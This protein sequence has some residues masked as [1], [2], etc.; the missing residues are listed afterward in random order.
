MSDTERIK[1]TK[2]K[3]RSIY[4]EI[5]DMEKK[6][7]I[8]FIV[9]GIVI[10]II[11]GMIT[12][13]SLLISGYSN[14]WSQIAKEEN[15][16]NLWDGDYGYDEYQERDHDID[17]IQRYMVY[18]ALF[19][20]IIGRIGVYIGFLLVFIG[21]L[22]FVTN[23]KIDERTRWICLIIAGVIIIAMVFTIMMSFSASVTVS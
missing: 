6:R 2:M 20:T 16:R 23:E 13:S 5:P 7:A 12:G 11:F 9:R 21:L 18:Q 15:K 1:K 10:V 4:D 19:F 14:T 22:G 8:K 3:K 17:Q